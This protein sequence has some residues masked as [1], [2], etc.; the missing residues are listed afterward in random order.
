MLVI[1]LWLV[2]CAVVDAREQRVPNA[3]TLSFMM[4]A[5]L[6]LMIYQ[7]TLAGAPASQGII[8]AG[9]ALLLTLPGFILG[10]MGGGDV[11]L[12][13]A[14]GFASSPSLVVGGFIY[15]TVALVLW[16]M[17][18]R[19]REEK[20]FAPFLLLGGVGEHAYSFEALIRAIS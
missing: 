10:R 6:Q 19:R 4:L 13:V 20:A 15:A 14:L 2:A 8:A 3:L 9:L 18:T 12:L 7:L 17:V 11:K 1:W 16:V 5:L